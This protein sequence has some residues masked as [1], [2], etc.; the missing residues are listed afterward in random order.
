MLMK[1]RVLP[2]RACLVI[3]LKDDV[4]SV[5]LQRSDCFPYHFS[6]SGIFELSCRSVGRYALI[7]TNWSDNPW[8]YF[9]KEKSSTSIAFQD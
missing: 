5:D 2:N 6:R 4:L 8:G 3:S 9:D 1:R 7:R